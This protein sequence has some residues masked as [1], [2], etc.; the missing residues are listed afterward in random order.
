MSCARG[1]CATGL[2][3]GPGEAGLVLVATRDA[4]TVEGEHELSLE[5]YII[6]YKLELALINLSISC[7]GLLFS[8]LDLTIQ[9]VV[10]GG[11]GSSKTEL[12]LYLI[13]SL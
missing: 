2:K 10:K 8:V 9:P 11:S 6:I 1:R 13:Y 12:W 7:G 5:D 3:P 4:E